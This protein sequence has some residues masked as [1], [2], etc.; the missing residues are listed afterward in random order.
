MTLADAVR[1]V[2]GMMKERW[3][4]L[5]LTDSAVKAVGL[6]LLAPLATGV[7]HLSLWVAGTG[8]LADADIVLFFIQPLGWAVLVTAGAISVGIVAAEQAT[9][10]VMVMAPSEKRISIGTAIGFVV[11][12][13]RKIIVLAGRLVAFTAAAAAPFLVMAVMTASMLLGDYDINFY[14]ATRP[15]AF[16]LA[17]GIGLVLGVGLAMLLAWLYAGWFLA[18]PIVLFEQS[19]AG[20]AMQ[21][22]RR[23]MAG[24]KQLVVK[25]IIG[26]GIASLMVSFLAT[27]AVVLAA[28]Q[29][30]PLATG[31]LA[32]L[33]FAIGSTL[34]IWF[35]VGL[36]IN[37]L[38][39]T[40]FATMI[41]TVYRG[42]SHPQSVTVA[43]LATRDT[44]GQLLPQ[45]LVRRRVFA[46]VAAGCLLVATFAGVTAEQM[47][48]EDAV[49]VMGHRGAGG[50]A[51][52]NTLA[53][54]QKAIDAGAD[55]V[56][57]DVQETADGEVVVVH[58]SD[59][60]KLA[61][62]NLKV[63]DATTADLGGIDVGRGFGQ[64]FVGERVPT[65]AEVLEVCRGRVGVN[66]ELKDYGHGQRLEERVAEVVE[67]CGMER[68]V[69]LMSLK[70]SVVKR[71]KDLRPEWTVGLLMSVAIGDAASLDADFL[72]VNARFVSRALVQR[73]HQAGK[74]VYAW[75]LN[76]AVGLSTLISRGVDGVI[77][78]YPDLA[79]TVL[80]QRARLSP[81]ERVLLEL[82]N[83]LGVKVAL[84]GLDAMSAGEIT[85]AETPDAV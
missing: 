29:F 25:L 37:V 38:A 41:A 46:S 57:I 56:E 15:G 53:A 42:L 49:E 5:F 6:I 69:I 44:N 17:V 75:T 8:T 7:L 76:D 23:R 63:W 20:E 34:T 19:S 4:L 77:T 81:V 3:R 55:W 21:V 13:W 16:Q 64:D 18:L 67:A 26:W 84:P 78:D 72:A 14:L 28:R 48:F 65:L 47:R 31:G 83:L 12:R 79:A 27:S 9:L 45:V 61:G 10:L 62:V 68:E 32:R 22:S 33:V 58:D 80:Q 2:A 51:P 11:A 70:P 52:E 73:S 1:A 35:A 60:M 54:V 43:P 85:T 36:L 24:N 82:A 30:V 50:L 59:F 71:M 39:S 66:I 74:K 40:V